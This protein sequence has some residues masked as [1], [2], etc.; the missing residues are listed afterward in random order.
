MTTYDTETIGNFPKEKDRKG[1]L[2][3]Q[4]SNNGKKLVIAL[5]RGGERRSEG[6]IRLRKKLTEVTGES[7]GKPY[8]R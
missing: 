7:L 3:N 4:R 1:L 2:Y 6:L 5:E 8:H